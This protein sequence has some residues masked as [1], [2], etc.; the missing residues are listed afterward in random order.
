[1]REELEFRGQKWRQGRRGRQGWRSPGTK[2]FC[3]GA[4]LEKFGTVKRK[5]SS[6][7]FSCCFFLNPFCLKKIFLE[8]EVMFKLTSLK[9]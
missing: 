6:A 4:M 7:K 5:S 1:M 8:E 9:F 2:V 3:V